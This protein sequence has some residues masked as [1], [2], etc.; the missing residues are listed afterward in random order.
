MGAALAATARTRRERMAETRKRMVVENEGVKR[1]ER[2]VWDLQEMLRKGQ[3]HSAF[4]L[5]GVSAVVKSEVAATLEEALHRFSM[6]M[7]MNELQCPDQ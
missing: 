3:P 5:S 1:V 4:I 6:E 7:Q 2:R